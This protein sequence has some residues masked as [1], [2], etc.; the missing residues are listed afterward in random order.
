[1]HASKRSRSEYPLLET[2]G[3]YERFSTKLWLAGINQN[4][5]VADFYSHELEEVTEAFVAKNVN[6][7]GNKLS[8]FA[9]T[10]IEPAIEEMEGH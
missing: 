8:D 4:W 1:M 6:H 7:A 5:E 3:Y 9:S 10:M 2:M